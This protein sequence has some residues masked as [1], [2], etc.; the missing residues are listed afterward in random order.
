M[1][2]ILSKDA[3]LVW[4]FSRHT[5]ARRNIGELKTSCIHLLAIVDAIFALDVGHYTTIFTM[6]SAFKHSEKKLVM[7]DSS[8]QS[9]DT[10]NLAGNDTESFWSRV[11]NVNVGLQIKSATVE[12]SLNLKISQKCV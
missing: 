9:A 12:S 6:I 2:S 1:Q 4:Y 10:S 8:F 7:F 3:N 11:E 5:T